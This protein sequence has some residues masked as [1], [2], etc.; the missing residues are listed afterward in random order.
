[1]SGRGARRQRR[2]EAG[3]DPRLANRAAPR[4]PSRSMRIRDVLPG[5]LLCGLIAL[6]AVAVEAVQRQATGRAWIEAIVLAIL[7]GAALRA[8]WTP[9]PRWNPGI[10]LSARQLLETAVVLM[11]ASVD[12][13]LLLRAG[14]PLAGGVVLVVFVGIGASYML[15]RTLGLNR[16]LAL[17]VAC[18]NSICGNSAIVAVAPAIEADPTDVA[19]AI[20]FTAVLGVGVVLA[21][22]LLG[23]ALHYT[24]FQFGVLAG[25]SVYAVPQ[26]LAATLAYDPLS[27]Q[28]GTLVKLVRVLMLGPVVVLLAYLQRRSKHRGTLA[29]NAPGDAPHLPPMRQLV[30]WF[31]VGFVVLA[32]L[33]AVGLFGVSEVNRLRDT[34]KVLTILAMAA[35]GLGVDVRSVGRGG[36]AVSAAVSLSLAVL[37]L[38][39][40]ALIA[41]LRLA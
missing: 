31:I 29:A 8:A 11:G 18:G 33:R 21:L 20:A 32:G 37:V 9:S 6:V 34:A 16:R 10:D 23:H 24:A 38:V 3:T 15:S 14:L 4:H 7:L 40:V 12:L 39:S 26:V 25:L 17:L 13:P 5:L 27:A 36:V 19:S 1:M 28:V 2:N 30:P 41:L 35:L 22:P